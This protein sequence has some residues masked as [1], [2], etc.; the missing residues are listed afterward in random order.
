M[1]K[2]VLEGLYW[3]KTIGPSVGVSEGNVEFGGGILG[4]KAIMTDYQLELTYFNII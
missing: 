3:I 1:T 2:S 4:L